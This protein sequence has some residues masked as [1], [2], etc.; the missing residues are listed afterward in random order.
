MKEWYRSA[1]VRMTLTMPVLVDD[2]M[3]KEEQEQ[4]MVNWAIEEVQC[5]GNRDVQFES[6]E[7]N[8]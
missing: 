3:T 6:V 4:R 5:L 2:E 7:F 1:T 8:D